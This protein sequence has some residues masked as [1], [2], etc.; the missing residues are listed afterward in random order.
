MKRGRVKNVLRAVAVDASF[1]AAAAAVVDLV[2]VA[3]VVDEITKPAS[4]ETFLDRS[5]EIRPV[6]FRRIV[7][8]VLDPLM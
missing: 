3:V 6:D 1:A 8:L 5:G 2:A 4:L 7:P